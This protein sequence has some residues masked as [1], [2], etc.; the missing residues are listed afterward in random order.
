[1]NHQNTH[2]LRS[3]ERHYALSLTRSRS[4]T[5]ALNSQLWGY[6]HANRHCVQT[7]R[8]APEGSRNSTIIRILN[9]LH[10]SWLFILI[11]SPFTFRQLAIFSDH[12]SPFFR[13]F[14][15]FISAI[16][17]ISRG[18]YSMCLQGLWFTNR[19]LCTIC[20]FAFVVLFVII[21]PA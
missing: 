21:L 7:P 8:Q 3:S 6:H 9:T 19:K 13:L 18:D 14:I 16:I 20:S 2:A 4:L 12:S 10:S 17:A 5:R 11:S 15:G 1:M